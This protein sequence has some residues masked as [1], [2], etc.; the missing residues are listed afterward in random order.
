MK[1][2]DKIKEVDTRIKCIIVIKKESYQTESQGRSWKI[3]N[4]A[5]K[6]ELLQN[7]RVFTFSEHASAA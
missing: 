5:S 7:K 2:Q 3:W 4:P 1:H 6:A